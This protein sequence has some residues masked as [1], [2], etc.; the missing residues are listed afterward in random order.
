MRNF[1]FLLLHFYYL[2]KRCMMELHTS[3][4]VISRNIWIDDLSLWMCIELKIRMFWY[5]FI[6]TLIDHKFNMF[7]SL[8]IE[9]TRLRSWKLQNR[10]CPIDIPDRI[11]ELIRRDK[12]ISNNCFWEEHCVRCLKNS[13]EFLISRI[14]FDSIADM[15]EL[16]ITYI[17]LVRCKMR[18]YRPKE[19]IWIAKYFSY[20]CHKIENYFVR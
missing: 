12:S 7:I 3:L 19:S 9:S 18:K 20:A 10:N 11:V 16:R 8:R 14:R 4:L 17:N 5:E 6:K 1:S 15:I 2:F 13:F